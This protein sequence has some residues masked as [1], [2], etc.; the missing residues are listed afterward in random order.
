MRDGKSEPA[1]RYAPLEFI[2]EEKRKLSQQL[3]EVKRQ[4]EL[5]EHQLRLKRQAEARP[6]AAMLLRL[7]NDF[8]K[9]EILFAVGAIVA[10][11]ALA[12]FPIL[13][14]SQPSDSGGVIDGAIKVTPPLARLGERRNECGLM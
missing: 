9:R 5:L 4:N 11:A 8:G 10:A 3:E 1:P 7:V 2:A 14:P 12:T 13:S 6:Q